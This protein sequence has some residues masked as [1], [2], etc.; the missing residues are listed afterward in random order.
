MNTKRE[1][2][3]ALEGAIHD[4]AAK[5]DAAIPTVEAGAELGLRVQAMTIGRCWILDEEV[6]GFRYKNELSAGAWAKIARKFPK[7]AALV[8]GEADE[9]I[10][11]TEQLKAIRA[12]AK[13]AKEAAR[14]A[15]AQK[16]AR[17]VELAG[18]PDP[19]V[20]PNAAANFGLLVEATHTSILP[21]F[22]AKY[23]PAAQ[24]AHELREAARR[25]EV[26]DANTRREQLIAMGRPGTL[27][28]TFVAIPFDAARA[29]KDA[30]IS[31]TEFLAKMA[32]KVE[33]KITGGIEFSGSL[34]NDCRLEVE[35]E[36]GRQVW[37]TRVILNFSG[38]GTPY[39]QWPS[40]R[41]A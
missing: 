41:A 4:I 3:K 28:R 14:S 6:E 29:E 22:I 33:A 19:K 21:D 11:L 31:F 26:E 39:H 27:R 9:A 38:L 34:W 23:V 30:R 12:E 18:A 17:K 5:I 13:A 2:E 25:K 1:T 36:T 15:R 24:Q 10:R 16:A 8:S 37:F 35:T 7:V 40:R 32:F 20:N